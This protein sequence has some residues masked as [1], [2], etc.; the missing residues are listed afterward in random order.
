MIRHEYS[1]MGSGPVAANL[2]V[3]GRADS[4]IE[5]LLLSPSYIWNGQGAT[6]KLVSIDRGTSEDKLQACVES[7]SR[8]ESDTHVDEE[9]VRESFVGRVDSFASLSSEPLRFRLGLDFAALVWERVRG[10]INAAECSAA[11]PVC[12]GASIVLTLETTVPTLKAR[13]AV[14]L[15]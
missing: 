10:R 9:L 14:Q 11:V 8:E 12:D 2:W 13:K 1:N 7:E 3:S 4:D 6:R 5:D 15:V